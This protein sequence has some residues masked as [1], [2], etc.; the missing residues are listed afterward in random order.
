MIGF[1]GDFKDTIKELV[2]GFIK[3]ETSSQAGFVNLIGGFFI[4]VLLFFP[5]FSN[6]LYEFIN[7]A[8]DLVSGNNLEVPTF[9]IIPFLIG[10]FVLVYY[11]KECVSNISNVNKLKEE[12]K[13]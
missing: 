3:N 5:F 2:T 12:N 11:F 7:F 8:A 13:D 9:N 4:F 6:A 1:D 10:A